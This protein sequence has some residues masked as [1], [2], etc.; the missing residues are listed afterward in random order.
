MSYLHPFG[1]FTDADA[2]IRRMTAHGEQQEMLLG[3]DAVVAS[4]DLSE[5]KKAPDCIPKIGLVLVV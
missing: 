5:S 1:D 4:L 2:G 3:R